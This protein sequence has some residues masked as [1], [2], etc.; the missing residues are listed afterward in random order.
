MFQKKTMFLKLSESVNP[1]FIFTKY[2]MV[3]LKIMGMKLEIMVVQEEKAIP[4]LVPIE[5]KLV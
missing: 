3:I 1:K 4:T 5:F 2:N